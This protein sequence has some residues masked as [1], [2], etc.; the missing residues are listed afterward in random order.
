MNDRNHTKDAPQITREARERKARADAESRAAA[1]EIER[2]AR[3]LARVREADTP[4]L[5]DLVDDP[6]AIPMLTDVLPG[7]AAAASLPSATP[8][9]S[10]EPAATTGKAA[11]LNEEQWNQM[12]LQVHKEVMK[13]MLRRTDELVDGVLRDRL[14]ELLDRSAERLVADLKNTVQQ[15][16]SEAVARAIAE[17]LGTVRKQIKKA[18]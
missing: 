11:T 10:A 17:E 15:S 8:G 14:D 7:G 16:V 2:V 3:D 6:D 12:A 9:S 4:D 1:E 13:S 18:T 5:D